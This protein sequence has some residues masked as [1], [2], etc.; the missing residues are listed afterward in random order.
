[1]T[2]LNTNRFKRFNESSKKFLFTRS[3]KANLTTII[4]I[5]FQRNSR[6]AYMN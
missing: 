5:F 6:V 1:M 3:Q 2:T 4:D